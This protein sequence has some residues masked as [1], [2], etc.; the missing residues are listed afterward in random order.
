MYAKLYILRNEGAHTCAGTVHVR[1]RTGAT[2]ARCPE[3]FA[4][5]VRGTAQHAR[6]AQQ[7]GS[8][9]PQATNCSLGGP[10]G[11]V[12]ERDGIYRSIN[13]WRCVWDEPAC[14]LSVLHE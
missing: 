2:V 6:V 7:T 9:S 11:R 13:Q 1:T 12:G 4:N 5:D 8:L 14:L 10:Q 3:A